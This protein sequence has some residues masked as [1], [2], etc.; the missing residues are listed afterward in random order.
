M[1]KSLIYRGRVPRWP[2]GPFTPGKLFHFIICPVILFEVSS[3]FS[4]QGDDLAKSP[5]IARIGNS[6][7]SDICGKEDPLCYS[8]GFYDREYTPT[9]T[10]AASLLYKMVMNGKREGVV[11]DDSLF[12]EVYQS[13]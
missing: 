1:L 5:H 4:P 8:F 13:K 10:M 6:V 2:A 12:K 9:P 11:L 7:Y 3:S